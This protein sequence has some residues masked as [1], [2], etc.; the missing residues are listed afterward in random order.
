[1][2]DR[3]TAL[4]TGAS[5]GIGASV[6]QALV[7]A[8]FYVVGTATSESGTEQISAALGDD[9]FGLVLKLQDSE[10]GMQF[11]VKPHTIVDGHAR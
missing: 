9:G 1:M 11:L 3:V 5:R 2:S 4:V 10:M 6:A 7:A 8:G